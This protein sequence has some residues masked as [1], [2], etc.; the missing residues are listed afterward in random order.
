M[1]KTLL[2]LFFVASLSAATAQNSSY[3]VQY[4][5][6][7]KNMMHKGDI[8]AKADL[9]TLKDAKH[10]YALGALENLKGEILILNGK[11][12]ISSTEAEN[13]VID[14]TLG[15]KA[16]LLVYSEVKSWSTITIPD[17]VS[18]YADLE[19]Y[20]ENVARESGINTDEPFPFLVEGTAESFNWH[21][22]N[23]KDG[24][25]EHSHQKHITSGPHGTMKDR[26]VEILGF[27][28]KSH[29]AIFTHHSTNMHLHVKTKDNQLAGHLDDIT[30][31]KGLI[32]KLPKN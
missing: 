10:L 28:S 11:P 21:V 24:D 6:A 31:G 20:I 25:M 30:L 9:S 17:S 27:Y 13:V 15:H 18:S 7:L 12:Y 26:E 16:T 22:I 3:T 32:L 8:S 4:Q 29:H 2:F 19:K 1:K 23:W 14:H 5:G